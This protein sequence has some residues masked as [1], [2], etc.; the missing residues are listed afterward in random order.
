MQVIK[1]AANALQRNIG[2]LLIYLVCAVFLGELFVGFGLLDK[3]K[4]IQLESPDKELCFLALHV[5]V[6]IGFATVQ[7]LVF[8]RMAREIDHPMWKTSGDR[9]A[10]RRF[11]GL[12][13]ALGLVA[14]ILNQFIMALKGGETGD[15][16]PL[17][18]LPFFGWFVVRVAGV[19]VCTCLMFWGKVEAGH[20]LEALA[21]LG[22]QFANVLPLLAL[23]L[24]GWLVQDFQVDLEQ[25]PA[26]VMT[27]AAILLVVAN[28]IECLVFAGIWIVC[29]IDRDTIEEPDFDF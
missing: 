15:A 21:P 10:L 26:L 28:Y 3:H 22:R 4:V 27:S 18:L 11:F 12:W 19:P 25:H 8:S 23:Y 1:D 17:I 24:L 2:P 29:M 7:C 16:H 9:E 20:V 6:A 13:V 5:L 14:V